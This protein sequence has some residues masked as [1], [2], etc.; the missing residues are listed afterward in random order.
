VL[1]IGAD[2]QRTDVAKIITVIVRLV[3]MFMLCYTYYKTPHTNLMDCISLKNNNNNNNNNNNKE[4]IHGIIIIIIK[5][6]KIRSDSYM[7]EIMF[8]IE[9]LGGC[10]IRLLGLLV[11]NESNRRERVVVECSKVFLFLFFC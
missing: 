6:K 9:M 4:L 1:Y 5:I 2:S 3:F 11:M 8:D 10:M 7:G